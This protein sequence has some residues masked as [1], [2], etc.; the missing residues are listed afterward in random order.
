MSSSTTPMTSAA[1]AAEVIEGLDLHPDRPPML[2]LPQV[3]DAASWART[4]R[5]SV[6]ATLARHGALLVRGLGLADIT[7]TSQV[8][9]TLGTG[10]LSEREG[11][12]ARTGYADGIYSSSTWPAGQPMCMHHELSYTLRPPGTMLF[13]CLHAAT[14]GGATGVADAA[15]VLAALPADL[16]ARFERDGWILHRRYNEDIGAAVG[17]A[18]GTDDPGRVEA[19]CRA[20]GIAAQWDSDGSLVTRQRRPAVVTH[21]TSGR[22]CWFNQVAFLS[23]WTLDPEVRE[24]LVDCYGPDGL[25][26]T[27]AYGDGTPIEPEVVQLLTDVYAA[28]T[29]R[30]AWQDG[31]LLLVDNIATAHSREPYTG[32]REVLVGMTDQVRSLPEPVEPKPDQHVEANPR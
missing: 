1:E 29:R 11:F 13:A 9:A 24:F 2:R 18:F 25:P 31:D 20:N 5:D 12:A 17:D 27:T 10:L 4:H 6:R 16:V 21:P 19:Y 14:D 30:E 26:F 7:T 23:E 28:H 15:D 22:R 3:D 8:F 32:S